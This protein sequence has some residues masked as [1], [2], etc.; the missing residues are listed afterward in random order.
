MIPE[1][2]TGIPKRSGDTNGLAQGGDYEPVLWTGSILT[3][4]SVRP[5][6][7]GGTADG[8]T[9]VN[10]F[11]W[12]STRGGSLR[13]GSTR[14]AGGAACTTGVGCCTTTLRRARRN[15]AAKPANRSTKQITTN[16]KKIEFAPSR[17]M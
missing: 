4:G 15:A 3:T 7:S 13:T 16:R 8:S 10:G 11:G 9:R 1:T 6:G 12:G 14:A 17:T 5:G 2:K